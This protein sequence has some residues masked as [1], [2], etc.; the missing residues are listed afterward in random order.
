MVSC[1]RVLLLTYDVTVSG[2]APRSRGHGDSV[3]HNGSTPSARLPGAA[4]SVR[5]A[6]SMC[7]PGANSSV[8]GCVVVSQTRSSN[9]GLTPIASTPEATSPSMKTRSTLWLSVEDV[10]TTLP[11]ALMFRKQKP[12]ANGAQ[13]I[14]QLLKTTP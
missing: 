7:W 6:K 13:S 3:P 1:L 5:W 11:L 10:A 2:S 9:G 14:S 12:A 8:Q 4:G